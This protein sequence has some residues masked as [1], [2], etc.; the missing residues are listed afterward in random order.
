MF[1]AAVIPA[2]GGNKSLPKKN[3]RELASKPL[4][5]YSIEYAQNCDLIDYTFVSSDCPETIS[6]AKSLGVEV[7]FARPA[8]YAEDDTR[9]YPF[10]RHALDALEQHLGHEID[11]FA[12][13]RPTSPLR[14]EGLIEKAFAMMEEDVDATSVRTV[15][16]TDQHPYR[17]FTVQSKYLCSPFEGQIYEHEPYNVPR[18]LLPNFYYQTGDLELVRGS[19]LLSGSVSG[20]RIRG[21]IIDKKDVIDIDEIE[22]FDRAKRKIDES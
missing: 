16:E 22:D 5:Q 18:Q 14:P 6:I 4:I 11:Y 1:I 15:A 7:P 19:T 2:R 17:Q 9:D 3:I 20:Q 10:M 13:L 21:L 12:L 8:E